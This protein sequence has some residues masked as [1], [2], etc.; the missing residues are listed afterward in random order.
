MQRFRGGEFDL[1][2]DALVECAN[3]DLANASNLWNVGVLLARL[4]DHT[5]ALS[6]ME[7]ALLRNSS[8][9]H[10]LVVWSECYIN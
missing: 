6:W 1:A 2:I 7:A 8:N 4:R 10:Y 3:L 5:N 9:V